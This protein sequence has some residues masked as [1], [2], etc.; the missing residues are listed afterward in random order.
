MRR[1]LNMSGE[2]GELGP[3]TLG[4]S[5]SVNRRTDTRTENTTF[6]T[7]LAG[8]NET[9]NIPDTKRNRRSL[10]ETDNFPTGCNLVTQGGNLCGDSPDLISHN[11]DSL[12]R[13]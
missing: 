1:K 6:A 4:T 2:G 11:D 10:F 3:C 9:I 5:H 7:P 12:N 13:F 8:G